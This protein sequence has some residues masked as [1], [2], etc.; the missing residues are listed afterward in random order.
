MIAPKG[1]TAVKSYPERIKMR[2][3]LERRIPEP[4]PMRIFTR[5]ENT[6]TVAQG[7]TWARKAYVQ[8]ATELAREQP[9]KAPRGF[10]TE[11]PTG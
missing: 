8:L 11:A 1:S 3:T 4:R 10:E 7:C 2:Y 9:L 5:E 6:S